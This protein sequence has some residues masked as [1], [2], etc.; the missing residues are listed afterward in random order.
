MRK[1]KP[2]DEGKYQVTISNIHGEDTA[3]TMLYVS[4]TWCSKRIIFSV[5]VAKRNFCICV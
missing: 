3:E 1:V 2:T 4:G 5:R